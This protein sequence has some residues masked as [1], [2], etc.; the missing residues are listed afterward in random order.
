MNKLKSVLGPTD[1]LGIG[2]KIHPKMNQLQNQRTPALA[3]SFVQYK[4]VPHP[5]PNSNQSVAGLSEKRYHDISLLTPKKY[6]T[7]YLLS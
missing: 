6:A 1:G 7:N 2:V 3:I 5:P 4:C